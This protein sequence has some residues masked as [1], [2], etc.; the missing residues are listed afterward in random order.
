MGFV[1]GLG[2]PTGMGVPT[3]Y[4]DQV[5]FVPFAGSPCDC[6]ALHGHEGSLI[7]NGTSHEI[8]VP[9]VG[10]CTGDL[11]GTQF[12]SQS[13]VCTGD[14]VISM[15]AWINSNDVTSSTIVSKGIHTN[16]EWALYFDS[17]DKLIF[18][19]YDETCYNSGSGDNYIQVK[20][21]AAQNGLEGSWHWIIATYDA[22]EAHTG[23][24]LYVDGTVLASTG[25]E[26]NGYNF[27]E[28]GN[29]ALV[30]GAGVA[31]WGNDV[32]VGSSSALGGFFDGKMHDMSG[33]T[34]EL[35]A[36][37]I[38][39]LYNSGHSYI[40]EIS[41]GNAWVGT[42]DMSYSPH[43]TDQS[44]SGAVNHCDDL[45]LYYPGIGAGTGSIIDYSCNR[46]TG[47]G[48]LALSLDYAGAWSPNVSQLGVTEKVRIWLQNSVGVTV[49]EWSNQATGDTAVDAEQG[50]SGNQAAVSGGGL[51]FDG[52][53]NFYEFKDGGG[54]NYDFAIAAQ[55]GLT[56]MTVVE[57][58]GVS[59]NATVL[60]SGSGDAHFFHLASGGDNLAI[61]LGGDSTSIE[62]QI[63]NLHNTG[64]KVLLTVV[65]KAGAIG[66]I[67][68]YADGV[69][70]LLTSVVA[71]P[72]DGEFDTL[73][74]RSGDEYFDGKIYELAMWN[75]A[76]S[77]EELLAAHEYFI[78]IHSL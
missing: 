2:V 39:D 22:S 3:Y 16:R 26:N 31:R 69:K 74:M 21:D 49:G 54:S 17:A 47:T 28:V 12:D 20:S 52:G 29:A 6:D 34:V 48:T 15:G 45:I 38:T 8:T 73:G 43:Y 57:R 78:S 18:R 70:Q 77:A 35:E 7:F 50:T 4:I 42:S 66:K 24:T 27:S 5:G 58:D 14:R 63:Q 67:D 11:F 64:T 56:I 33:W 19:I 60:S 36:G 59:G 72:G 68:F 30:T 62:P 9:V 41:S 75:K 46:C 65:R 40:Y 13:G 53:D 55:E 44:T 1:A 32:L 51:D 61:K 23:M 71:N 10:S 25:S 76:L 37:T